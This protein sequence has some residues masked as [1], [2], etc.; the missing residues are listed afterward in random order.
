[1]CRPD[2]GGALTSRGRRRRDS[3]LGRSGT[4]G[5]AGRRCC[6]ANEHLVR[7]NDGQQ[8][9]GPGFRESRRDFS[10]H[11]IGCD[12]LQGFRAKYRELARQRGL[13]RGDGVRDCC[14][15]RLCARRGSTDQAQVHRY[16]ATRRRFNMANGCSPCQQLNW[17]RS[18]IGCLH[19]ARS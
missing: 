1:M 10:A 5:S 3:K 14:T 19:A 16:L 15:G 11:A 8:P 9:T 17:M 2:R 12:S 4:A 13:G 7:E 18:K 6:R